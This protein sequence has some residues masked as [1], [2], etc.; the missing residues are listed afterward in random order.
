M[1]GE[2]VP[3]KIEGAYRYKERWRRSIWN[4]VF[5][6]VRQKHYN[7]DGRGCQ[8]IQLERLYLARIHILKGE[9]M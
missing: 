5:V 6:V 1:I 2:S 7:S 3:R 9:K 8:H 4:L